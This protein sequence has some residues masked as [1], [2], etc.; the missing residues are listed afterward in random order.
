MKTTYNVLLVEKR[1]INRIKFTLVT[2]QKIG[3]DEPTTLC[4]D[5]W[6]N[7]GAKLIVDY[8]EYQLDGTYR[9]EY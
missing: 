6:P 4:L 1:E 9:R 3:S 7:I 5:N 2:C 8:E